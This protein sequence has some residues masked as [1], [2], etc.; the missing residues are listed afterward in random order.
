MIAR[1]RSLVGEKSASAKITDEIAL[2]ILKEY[3]TDCDA[4][5]RYGVLERLAKK[6]NLPAQVV[7]RLTA[8]KTFRHLVM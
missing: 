6:H 3:K 2:S 5:R 8:R 4:G 7:S 1:N